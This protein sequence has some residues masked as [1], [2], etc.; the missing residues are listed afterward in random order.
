M[1]E[2]DSRSH[3]I[4]CIYPHSCDSVND[5]GLCD[6]MSEVSDIDTGM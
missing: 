1:D 6:G 3:G 5:T 4:L 2:H